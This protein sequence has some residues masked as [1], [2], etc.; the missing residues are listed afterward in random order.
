MTTTVHEAYEA[1][2]A[3]ARLAAR[4][5][6][7]HMCHKSQLLFFMF[8][9]WMCSFHELEIALLDADQESAL[10]ITREMTQAVMFLLVDLQAV[11]TPREPAA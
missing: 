9:V 4:H 11:R 8:G 6:A 2:R 1:G 10:R 7:D 3:V 5:E